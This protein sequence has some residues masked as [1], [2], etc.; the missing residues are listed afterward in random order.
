M[1]CAKRNLLLLEIQNTKHQNERIIQRENYI[2]TLPEKNK[3]KH[4]DIG[5]V[6]KKDLEFNFSSLDERILNIEL[7]LETTG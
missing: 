7:K 6:V 5:F 2:M 1:K 3:S 4:H